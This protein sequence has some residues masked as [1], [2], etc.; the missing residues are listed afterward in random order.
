MGFYSTYIMP[1]MV[2]CACGTG[3]I[4]WERK[5]IIPK[6]EGVVLE[7]GVG[8]GLNFPY[9]DRDKVTKL[10]ALEPDT[11][12]RKLA[13]GAVAKADFEIEWLSLPGEQIPLGDNSVDTVVM[14]FTL[15]TIPD[16]APALAG[17][18]RVLK[19]GGQML[20][21]EHGLAPDAG[22]AKWQSRLNSVWGK[23]AGGCHLNRDITGLVQGGG[24]EITDLDQHYARGAPRFA[25]YISRGIAVEA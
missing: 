20:F 18:K 17:M 15:C 25:G 12:M 2:T 10:Y 3:A 23:M 8:P 11:T 21:A 16:T 7:I 4:R 6:A 5:N 19:P 9:Y 22:V 14:T 1:R 13:S 24:F